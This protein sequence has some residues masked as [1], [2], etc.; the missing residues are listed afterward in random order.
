MVHL[1][2]GFFATHTCLSQ[3]VNGEDEF[4]VLWSDAK[5]QPMWVPAS[6]LLDHWGLVRAWESQHAIVEV[7]SI[8][9]RRIYEGH[10]MYLIRWADGVYV[11]LSLGGSACF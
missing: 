9:N 6:R 4:L 3:H 2:L 8:L 10:V 5:V 1:A 11:A 7:Q